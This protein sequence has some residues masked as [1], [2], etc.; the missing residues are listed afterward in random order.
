MRQRGKLNLIN[1][2][3]YDWIKTYQKNYKMDRWHF[4]EIIPAK[5]SVE[6]DIE[7]TDE[8]KIITRSNNRGAANYMLFGSRDR[9]FQIH[10]STKNNHNC[11]LEIRFVNL[12][13]SKHPIGSILN[14]DWEG[15]GNVNFALSGTAD[16]FEVSNRKKR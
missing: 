10:A 1:R 15:N 9:C 6:I 7:W 16:E 13:T 12:K 8:Q 14:L 2:T 5:T 4:P 3:A 11:D